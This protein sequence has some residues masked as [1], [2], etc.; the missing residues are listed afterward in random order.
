MFRRL[1]AVLAA[2]AT[3]VVLSAPMAMAAPGDLD[4]TFGVGGLVH[5]DISATSDEA[6]AVALAPDGKIV[7]AGLTVFGSI[8]DFALARY[9]PDGSLDDTFDGDGIVRTSI[10]PSY[11]IAFAVAVQPDSKIVVA[12]QTLDGQVKSVL[13]RYNADG[14]L[15]S[16]FG[17]GGVTVT[18]LDTWF[19]SSFRAVAIQ[20]DGGIIVGGFAQTNRGTQGTVARYDR[21]G[22]LET[23]FSGGGVALLP[24]VRFVTGIAIQ[25]DGRLLASGGFRVARLHQDGTTDSGYGVDGVTTP[26]F[27]SDNIYDSTSMGVQPDQKVVIGGYLNSLTPEGSAPD[28]ALARFNFD[29]TLDTGYAGDGVATVGFVTDAADGINAIGIQ[30]DGKTV[31][32]GNA[33]SSPFGGADF[34]VARFLSSGGLDTG[35]G[36]GGTVRTEIAGV[37]TSYGMTVQPD[38]AIVAAGSNNFGYPSANSD[39][40]L[41]RYQAGTTAA[42]SAPTLHSI[43]DSTVAEGDDLSLTLRAEDPDGDTLTYWSEDL[44]DGASLNGSGVFAWTPGYTQAGTY[45]V[46]FKVSDNHAG[47]TRSTVAT[48]TVTNTTVPTQTTLSARTM[49]R[50]TVSGRVLP[51]PGSGQVEITLYRKIKKTFEILASD[52]PPINDSGSFS[53]TFDRPKETHECKVTAVYAGEEPFQPSSATL[54]F[55]C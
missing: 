25:D 53:S 6:K 27:T 41:A 21:L 16:S 38:G 14:T 20:Q 52:S 23:T 2:T 45:E 36:N 7:V 51:S 43:G 28:F 32:V 15:D 17:Q 5:T 19:G 9:R 29:G 10:G 39:I 30:T 47:H 22:V 8:A 12:G 26:L 4:P 40:T 49:K 54:I 44:P 31:A 33:Q 42:D 24:D 46:P 1:T 18:S 35:F 11:D 13:A 3:A 37:E 34:A 50:I 55:N 48:I